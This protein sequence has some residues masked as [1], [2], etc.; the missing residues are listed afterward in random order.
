MPAPPAPTTNVAPAA[1]SYVASAAPSPIPTTTPGVGS[2]T[3]SP[4]PDA[5]PSSRREQVSP[6]APTVPVE[7]F[8]PGPDAFGPPPIALEERKQESGSIEPE[9]R[10]MLPFVLITIGV[11]SLLAV[12]LIWLFS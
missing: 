5:S 1:K 9:Q 12:F 3:L 6:Y 4:S 7:V 10:S 11:L 8:D 2:A